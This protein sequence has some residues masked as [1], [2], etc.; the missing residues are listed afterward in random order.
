MKTTLKDTD[1]RIRF[2]NSKG[3]EGT[4]AAYASN[5]TNIGYRAA[6]KDADGWATVT[7]NMSALG[8]TDQAYSSVF[9]YIV[10]ST[11]NVGAN[12]DAADTEHKADTISIDYIS[13]TPKA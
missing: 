2:K 10:I 3:E 6:T 4:Y 11:A 13:V 5:L 1:Y 12:Y 7:I 8:L 9:D